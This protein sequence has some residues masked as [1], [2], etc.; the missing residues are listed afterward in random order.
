MGIA[1]GDFSLDGRGDLFVTNSRKQLHAV[2]RSAGARGGLFGDARP[3]L[4]PALGTSYTGW[5]ASWADLDLDQDLD[6]VLAN[7]AIPV[8]SLAKD[9]QRV[10][11]VANVMKPR[12]SSEFV[13]ARPLAGALANRRVNGR[14]LAAADYDNDGDLDVAV[15]SIGGR[16]MLLR[17]TGATGHWLEVALPR[18]A[19]GTIVTAKL[20]DGRSLV[21]E[22]HAGSSYLSSEDPRVHFGLGQRTIVP[23]LVVRYPGGR[24]IRLRNVGADRLITVT[25]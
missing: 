9:A 16:L 7:G 10:Q 3:E 6:L 11:V 17:N 14:G 1:A 22:V 23:E 8:L 20:A 19:P 18:F 24:T 2:Y 15:N 5:G 13:A 12:R 25:P 4:A 21:R